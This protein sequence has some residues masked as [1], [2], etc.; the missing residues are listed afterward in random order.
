[1][2][3][4]EAPSL[5]WPALLVSGGIAGVAGWV[6]T[7]P[8]DVVKTRMQGIGLALPPTSH[9]PIPS[10]SRTRGMLRLVRPSNLHTQVPAQPYRTTYTTLINSYHA[11]GLGVFYRGLAPTLIRYIETILNATT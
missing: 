6:A 7:F 2:R 9:S 8:F 3:K 1:M 11:E 5:S 10:V 4:H